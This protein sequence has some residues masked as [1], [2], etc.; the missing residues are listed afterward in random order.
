M[1]FFRFF[2]LDD[3]KWA[4]EKVIDIPAKTVLKDGEEVKLNGNDLLS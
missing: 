3:G 4:T 2:K 1:L